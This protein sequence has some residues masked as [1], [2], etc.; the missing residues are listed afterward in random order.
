[1]TA[2]EFLAESK[3]I[4]E[5]ATP[6]SW[7]ALR[8]DEKFS[9]IAV[10]DGSRYVTGGANFAEEPDLLVPDAEFIAHARTALLRMREALEA[11]LAVPQSA[12]YSEDG[13]AVLDGYTPDEAYELGV[14]RARDAIESAL[15]ENG[16][17]K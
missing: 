14:F 4:E 2:T 12:G 1:M 5:A 7:V 3:R 9:A 13:Y 17:E 11:V 10:A 6:G 15:A 16:E 8:H